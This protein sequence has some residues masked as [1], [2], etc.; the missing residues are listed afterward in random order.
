MVH[1]EALH[2][3]HVSSSG[4]PHTHA[5]EKYDGCTSSLHQRCS[6]LLVLFTL[7]LNTPTPAAST[8]PP[9]SSS[10]QKA[11]RRRTMKR[12][13]VFLLQ[14]QL[15]GPLVLVKDPVQTRT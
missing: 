7:T 1:V 13:N 9:S 14:W 3:S 2:R 15:P 11:P 10:E 6:A 5:Q 8:P 4:S 12:L